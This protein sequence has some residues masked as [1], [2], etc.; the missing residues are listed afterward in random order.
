MKPPAESL[1]P[2]S[3][4]AEKPTARALALLKELAL[5]AAHEGITI[6]DVRQDD[7]PIVYANEGFERLTGYGVEEVLGRNCRFLQG[8]GTD[9]AAVESLR[10]A[11]RHG[12]ACTV[13]ILNYRKDGTP[14]WNR[15]AI[16][17]VRD[18]DG[19][20]TNFVGIQSDTTARKKAEQDLARANKRMSESL[21]AAAAIQ[22][23]L[24]PESMPEVAGVDFAW[25]FEP[26][27]E[28][29]GDSLDA[30]RVDDENVAMYV[31]DVVGHGVPAALLS[32]TLSQILSF[33]RRRSR[34]AGK[35][36]FADR[37]VIASPKA[38]TERLNQLFPW[39][40][41]SRQY[42]TLFYGVLHRPTRRLTYVTA[43]H[44]AP[45]LLPERGPCRNLPVG[46]FPVGLVQR[47]EYEERT[48]DLSPGDRLYVYTDGL[49]EATRDDGCEFGAERLGEQ[50]ERGRELSLK[51]SVEALEA[52]A[53]GW[54]DGRLQ[55]DLSILALEI[56]GNPDRRDSHERGSST[57][58]TRYGVGPE[59]GVV[60]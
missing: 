36:S 55:D 30:F 33:S 4:D 40:Q 23:S 32:V 29:A 1:V 56:A 39:N 44:P 48:I 41:E 59:V 57:S 14:F 17:P 19:E 18:A 45:A 5:D 12:R 34:M 52:T 6:S 51:K 3:P 22:R 50:I 10:E 35:G 26:C 8:S 7:N 46:G 53:E 37:Q 60:G 11:V 16:T 58:S 38:A 43:G 54:A 20:L 49:I 21:E 27:Y 24:L 42:F 9:P 15:L 25:A 47:P 28:L 31:L 2:L 13:E